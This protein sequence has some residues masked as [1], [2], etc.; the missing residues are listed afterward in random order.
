M[1]DELSM[2]GKPIFDPETG[3]LVHDPETGMQ[4][5]EPLEPTERA[6]YVQALFDACE[7]Y[8]ISLTLL[9]KPSDRMGNSNVTAA[10]VKNY[11]IVGVVAI[12]RDQQMYGYGSIYLAEADV[13]ALWELQKTFLNYSEQDTNYVFDPD[14]IY[15]TL[16]L[17][18]D[19]STAQTNYLWT[20]YNTDSFDAQDTRLLLKGSYIE[21]LRTV[22]EMVQ[23]L[24]QIFLYVGL[25]LALFAILLFSNF[26][27]VSI[28][29]KKREIG[30]LRAV[31]ARS[32]D[33][34]K[35]F[36]SESFVIALIAVTLS[37]TGS[38]VL[39]SVLNTEL[40]AQL[41]ASIFVFGVPSIAIMLGIAFAT[42]VLATFLPVYHAARKKPVEFIRAL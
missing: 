37:V 2:G 18:Y 34:F 21:S 31:G 5:I 12:E 19:H 26:I 35:I 40:G 7:T 20:L 4:M 10:D 41:G 15:S 17:P 28:S 1:C 33:V 27:S 24:S 16:Y 14:A 25:A 13:N 42:A 32:I 38:A 8:G 29:Q 39:C 11:T 6:A 23:M 9:V 30:I 22:D 36:F 3:N